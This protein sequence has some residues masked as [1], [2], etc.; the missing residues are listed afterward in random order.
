MAHAFMR[1]PMVALSLAMTLVNAPA[2]QAQ[3]CSTGWAAGPMGPAVP[4]ADGPIHAM[5]QYSPPAS[6]AR[7]IV[8]GEFTHIGGIAAN[9]IAAWDGFG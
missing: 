8:G 5:I 1:H 3:P 2:L 9:N 4:G 7:L 6:P